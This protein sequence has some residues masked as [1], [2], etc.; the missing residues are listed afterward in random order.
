V[1]D[2]L[3]AIFPGLA[4]GRYRETS[5]ATPNCDYNCIAWAA[6]RTDHWWEPDP[7]QYFYWPPGVARQYTLQAYSDVYRVFGFEPCGSG[8]FEIA[9]EKIVLFATSGGVP[10]H[11][12]RQLESGRWTSKLGRDVDI[13]H[14][15]PDMLSGNSYG[16]PV[17]FMQRPRPMWR[18]PL[19]A[20][21]H[22]FAEF[23][24]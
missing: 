5:P 1:A 22:A 8:R 18:W 19:A 10:Q 24:T 12:A 16:Q 7:Y 15:T 13:E 14:T 17:L 3:V 9:S 20:L 23:R 21:K 2:R 4:H 11:A 6:S